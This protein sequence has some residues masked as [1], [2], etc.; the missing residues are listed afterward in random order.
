MYPTAFHYRTEALTALR[1]YEDPKRAVAWVLDRGIS[2]EEAEEL[3]EDLMEE[4]RC[5]NQSIGW[6]SM[7]TG[8]GL[9]GLFVILNGAGPSSSG[10]PWRSSMGT[11]ASCF[12]RRTA[13]WSIGSVGIS[14][15]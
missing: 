11:T 4:T 7:L 5:F 15:S 13:R 14:A 10:E 3:V 8:G 9:I 12:P 6:H 2:R 1:L